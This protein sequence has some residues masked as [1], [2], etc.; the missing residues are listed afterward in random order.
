MRLEED[1]KD[2]MSGGWRSERERMDGGKREGKVERSALC[3][4]WRCVWGR[5]FCLQGFRGGGTGMVERLDIHR[6][7]ERRRHRREKAE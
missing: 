2:E 7:G 5:F 4:G 1:G 3:S 6:P